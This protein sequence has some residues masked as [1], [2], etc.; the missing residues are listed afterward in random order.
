MS[1]V[2]YVANKKLTAM[3]KQDNFS[4]RSLAAWIVFGASLDSND[5]DAGSFMSLDTIHV[6]FLSRMP[7]QSQ[8]S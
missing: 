1:S 3:T 6:T 5:V 7:I 2:L 8:A 4:T